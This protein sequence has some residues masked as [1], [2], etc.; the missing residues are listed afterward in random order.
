MATEKQALRCAKVVT[1]DPAVGTVK[2]VVYAQGRIR[3]VS[4]KLGDVGVHV[5]GRRK[6]CSSLQKPFLP[7]SVNAFFYAG[8]LLQHAVKPFV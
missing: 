4:V 2:A 1:D 6:I 8:P 5:E 7:S 3:T